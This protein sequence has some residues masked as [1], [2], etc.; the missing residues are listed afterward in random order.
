MTVFLRFLAF[1]DR[2]PRS[3]APFVLPDGSR[4][5][6][7]LREV[8]RQWTQAGVGTFEERDS[9]EEQALLASEGK[10]L[11]PEEPLVEGQQISVIGSIL[12]G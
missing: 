7:L 11:Q 1:S 9:L 12:G 10:V 2:L 5:E 4:A 3:F 6:D 8:R